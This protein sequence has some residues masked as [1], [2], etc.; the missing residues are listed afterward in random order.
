MKDAELIIAVLALIVSIIAV[1]ITHR[2]G[3]QASK[4]DFINLKIDD[5]STSLD[6]IFDECID[7]ISNSTFDNSKYL[8]QVSMYVK[9]QWIVKEINLYDKNNELQRKEC[10]LSVKKIM[11]DDIF[12]SGDKKNCLLSLLNQINKLKSCFE[13]KF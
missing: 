5:L 6:R 13:R 10:L 7:I 4:H 11:T 8:Y 2:L 3:R 9:L 1:P 12:F